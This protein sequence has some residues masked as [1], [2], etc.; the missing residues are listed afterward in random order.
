MKIHAW[1][2]DA[3]PG[4]EDLFTVRL[5]NMLDESF[6]HQDDRIGFST[7]KNDIMIWKVG[8]PLRQMKTINP[9]P[10]HRDFRETSLIFNPHDVNII[11]IVTMAC[12]RV[13]EDSPVSG[14]IQWIVQKY[15]RDILV[16]TVKNEFPLEGLDYHAGDEPG[17]NFTLALHEVDDNGTYSICELAL[18]YASRYLDLGCHH[19]WDRRHRRPGHRMLTMQ[20]TFNIYTDTLST[21]YYHL[22]PGQ[23]HSDDVNFIIPQDSGK[24]QR[25]CAHYWSGL[26][27]LPTIRLIQSPNLSAT[28]PSRIPVEKALLLAVK[29]CD[30]IAGPPTNIKYIGGYGP[31]K[32]IW[33][34]KGRFP[35]RDL[36]LQYVWVGDLHFATLGQ[37]ANQQ[38]DL[39]DIYRE[40]R[41][42][43]SFVVLFGEY[44][45]VVWCFD[46]SIELPEQN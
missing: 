10:N 15:V 16:K 3:K 30:Q 6:I 2:L 46:R 42:D 33:N 25:D 8:G 37:E 14:N 43:G 22:P 19:H 26:M 21:V 38:R 39:N 24:F 31:S 40:V 18:N 27:M 44:D 17:H 32:R 36:G 35:T 29:S 20:I 4:E 11:Y 45:F 28:S 41:G 1:T 9:L 5:P 34:C 13:D 7:I 12:T 23:K